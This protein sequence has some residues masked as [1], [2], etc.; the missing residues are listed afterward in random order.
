[1]QG[2]ELHAIASLRTRPSKRTLQRCACKCGDGQL[3]VCRLFEDPKYS[4]L[5]VQCGSPE[6]PCA[7]A[8]SVYAILQNIVDRL[9]AYAANHLR[10]LSSWMESAR[11]HNAIVHS[12]TTA[13]VA[14]KRIVTSPNGVQPA[15]ESEAREYW[16]SGC[17]AALAI[18]GPSRDQLYGSWIL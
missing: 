10:A 4:D 16:C 6:W 14:T 15:L 7:Q 18:V 9:P 17:N 5:T 8:R 12:P 1:M 11:P 2:S 3:T 13:L